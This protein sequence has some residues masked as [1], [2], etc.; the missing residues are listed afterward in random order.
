MMCTSQ[1]SISI[2]DCFFF[3]KNRDQER[4]RER[5]R[6]VYVPRRYIFIINKIPS[7]RKVR[8]K[9]SIHSYHWMARSKVSRSGPIRAASFSGLEL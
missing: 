1:F 5:E 8:R 6:A 3:E 4:E 7:Y 2:G 9:A